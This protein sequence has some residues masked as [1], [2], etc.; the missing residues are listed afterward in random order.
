MEAGRPVERERVELPVSGARLIVPSL[1][2]SGERIRLDREQTRH[3]R[4]R[5]LAPGDPVVLVD[6]SG[7]EAHGRLERFDARGADVLVDAIRRTEGDSALRLR[8]LV[9]SVRAE[10]LAWIAEKATELGVESMVL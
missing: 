9:A 6:G 8:L 7:G 4:A 1:P 2:A 3:A 10:R 5:R